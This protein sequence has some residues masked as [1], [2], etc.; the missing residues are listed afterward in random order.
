MAIFSESRLITLSM[1]TTQATGK[2]DRVL[3]DFPSTVK[4]SIKGWCHQRPAFRIYL[5]F[6]AFVVE[7]TE[8]QKILKKSKL[9]FFRQIVI[10]TYVFAFKP[11]WILRSYAIAHF[12]FHEF[13]FFAKNCILRKYY[14]TCRGTRVL[15][16][17]VNIYSHKM[18]L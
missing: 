12:D 10:C 1:H 8:L 17:T 14:V 6:S 3:K 7:D 5:T 4:K 16:D 18:F 15:F 2:A 9:I 13:F 11:V